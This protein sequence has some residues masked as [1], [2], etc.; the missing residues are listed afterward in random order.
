ML[1]VIKYMI[2]KLFLCITCATSRKITSTIQ[3]KVYTFTI[4]VLFQI[5]GKISLT[6]PWTNLYSEPYNMIVHDVYLMAG[7]I[8]G[9]VHLH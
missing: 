5:A 2:C 6:I 3:V 4:Q 8:R 7:P 9:K 1:N